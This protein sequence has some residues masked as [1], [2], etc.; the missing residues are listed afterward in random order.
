MRGDVMAKYDL[1]AM[2]YEPDKSN[3]YSKFRWLETPQ[4]GQFWSLQARGL[5]DEGRA[6]LAEMQAQWEQEQAEKAKPEP[7][8]KAIAGRLAE[9]LKK[10]NKALENHR[11]I[12]RSKTVSASIGENRAALSEWEQYNA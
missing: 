10:A 12:P 11:Q 7:D 1:E 4:G 9:A 6:A 2:E 8:W 3:I 5:T